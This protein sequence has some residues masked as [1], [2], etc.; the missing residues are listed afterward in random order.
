MN[1]PKDTLYQD[2]YLGPTPNGGAYS[3]AFYF[4]NKGNQ[5]VKDKATSIKICE[6]DANGE[7]VFR[8]Y[9]HI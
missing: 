9:A 1:I 3:T 5:C 2:S 4:D 8:T 6:Y 7:Y